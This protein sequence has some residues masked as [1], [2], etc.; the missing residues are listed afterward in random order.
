MILVHVAQAQLSAH[1]I[2]HNVHIL[3]HTPLKYDSVYET[4]NMLLHIYNIYI[5]IHCIYNADVFSFVY[6]YYVSTCKVSY[7]TCSKLS[8]K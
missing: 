8:L 5:Y 1:H 4:R 7:T 2:V 3:T 6:T